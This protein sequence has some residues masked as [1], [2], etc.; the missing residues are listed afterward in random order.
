MQLTLRSR[1][2]FI[3]GEE[4]ARTTRL[5]LRNLK[6]GKFNACSSTGEGLV[7]EEDMVATVLDVVVF[8]VRTSYK[9]VVCKFDRIRTGR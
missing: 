3:L 1:S 6:M 7:D 5:S 8:V 4:E 2:S 9:L